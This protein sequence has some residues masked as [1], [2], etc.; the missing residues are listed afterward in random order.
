LR[1]IPIAKL[2]PLEEDVV[3]DKVVKYA[4]DIMKSRYNVRTYVDRRNSLIDVC[5][6]DGELL[7]TDGNH[8]VAACFVLGIE[9]V[10]CRVDQYSCQPAY[11]ACVQ[12][13]LA[14]GYKGFA[15]LPVV[16]SRHNGQ[17]L[18][19]LGGLRD[20]LAKEAEHRT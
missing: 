20:E 19:K 15:E 12:Q 10:P 16:T 14:G 4:R 8:A 5:K 9:T 6:V 18:G 1:D 7:V 13:A 3:R 11:S 2:V 17:H